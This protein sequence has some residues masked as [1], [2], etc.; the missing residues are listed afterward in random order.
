MSVGRS[1]TRIGSPAARNSA[2]GPCASRTTHRRASANNT[3][4]FFIGAPSRPGEVE[5]D[6][7]LLLVEQ[8]AQAAARQLEQ[9]LEIVFGK[10]GA[11][12]GGLDFDQAAGAGH[13]DV[14]VHLG[15]GVFFVGEVEQ[16]YAFNQA[17]AGGR[18]GV[19]QR[20]RPQDAHFNQLLAGERQ[21]DVGAG[22]G[23]GD[24]AAVGLDDVAGED[25]RA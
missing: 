23:G 13:Y 17:N 15:A 2:R 24:R 3:V 14:H 6:D 7:F 9:P 16:R 1:P 5:R 11:F 22:D 18:H 19:G 8:P 10:G 25:E 20:Q 12:G 21:G 4:S